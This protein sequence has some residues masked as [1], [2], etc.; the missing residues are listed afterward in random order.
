MIDFA[1]ITSFRL[2]RRLAMG[3][4]ATAMYLLICPREDQA[5]AEEELKAEVEL[6]LGAP[7][8]IYRSSE[9]LSWSGETASPGVPAVQLLNIEQWSLE[10]VA[11]LD[12]HVVRV[13]RNAAQL[14][15]LTTDAIAEQ[16]LVGAPNLRNR[17]TE[18][19]QFIPES[20]GGV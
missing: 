7:L 12:T 11:A 9:L 19:L 8:P 16:L 13:E 18:I 6:Q 2:V 5:E 4:G 1:I 14:L 17:L 15:F 10:L 3:E 20:D